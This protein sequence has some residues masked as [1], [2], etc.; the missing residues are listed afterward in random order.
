MAWDLEVRGEGLD[1]LEG[2][3]LRVMV[4]EAI[5][6]EAWVDDARDVMVSDGS[7][8]VE[9]PGALRAGWNIPFDVVVIADLDRD[10][11]CKPGNDRA[12]RISLGIPAGPAR[13]S[14][15]DATP[16]APDCRFWE[17][18]PHEIVLE[19]AGLEALEGRYAIGA[20]AWVGPDFVTLTRYVTEPIRDGTFR[21][22]LGGFGA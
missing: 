14:L 12:W 17:G 4:A 10:G 3:P 19:G 9:I 16:E 20:A 6:G 18:A 5:E 13:V 22:G 11:A 2:V 1:S 8:L 21:M 15:A 7:F